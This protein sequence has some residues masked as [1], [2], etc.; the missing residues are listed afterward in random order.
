MQRLCTSFHAPWPNKSAP[1]AVSVDI[2]SANILFED[3][4]GQHTLHPSQT[5]HNSNTIIAES[6]ATHC[7]SSGLCAPICPRHSLLKLRSVRT[8]L[9]TPLTA[10]AQIC[11]HH[12]AHGT[13][14]SS[15][16]LCTPLCSRHSLLKLRTV[17]TTLPT[18]LPPSSRRSTGAN[19]QWRP[20]IG[21][22][23]NQLYMRLLYKEKL[24]T[25]RSM[26][27]AGSTMGVE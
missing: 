4:G 27:Q 14:S 20:V 12:S 11:A 18:L 25:W 26:L 16:C 10:Q 22:Q 7:S 1:I 19:S 9:P 17:R 2:I 21:D 23:D 5:G 15:S 13:H 8:T 3:L 24:F 6:L